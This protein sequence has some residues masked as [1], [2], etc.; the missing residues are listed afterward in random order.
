MLGR[1]VEVVS[2]QTLDEFLEQRVFEPL[3][4]RDAGFWVPRVARGR[5]ATVYRPSDEGGLRPVQLES[6]PF[7][8]RPALIEG[9][10][11]LL[12][13]TVDFLRFSQRC[14]NGGE[15]D[16]V[17]L[18]TPETIAL[19]ATN[20]VPDALLPLGFGRPMLGIGWGLGFSIVMDRSEYAYP[21]S[22][23]EYWWDGS[24]GTRFWIGPAEDMVT[25]VMAQSS[26][27]RGNGFREEFKTL[28]YDALVD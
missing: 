1:I 23:G 21:V 16:S 19:M 17:R 24:A 9:G 4:M 25:I 5:L 22:N 10:I 12:S 7:T 20:Q 11:G 18:V 13:S 14:L 8:E 6:V 2:G 28:V 15:L 3:G 27:A 26:P